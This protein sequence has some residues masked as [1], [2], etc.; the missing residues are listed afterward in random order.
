[1]VI[2]K[3]ADTLAMTGVI[4]GLTTVSLRLWEGVTVQRQPANTKQNAQEKE[5][6]TNFKVSDA[7]RFVTFTAM[8][9]S[10]THSPRPKP[11]R[12]RT[13][14]PHIVLLM[15]RSSWHWHSWALFNSEKQQQ[16]QMLILIQNHEC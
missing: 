15:G 14:S 3:A 10:V 7:W 5:M 13:G 12:T 16:Q 11:L 2:V 9:V 8:Q 1:M 4:A 6:H